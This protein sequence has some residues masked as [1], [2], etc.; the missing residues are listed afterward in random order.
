M[1][2]DTHCHLDASEFDADR[3]LVIQSAVLAGVRCIVIPAVEVANFE[4]VR[5][6]AHRLPHGAYALGIHP[7]FV[8]QAGEQDLDWLVQAL[9]RN[10]DDPKLVAVGEIGLD[11]FEPHLKDPPFLDKQIRIFKAQLSIAKM[12]QLPVILH[13]R[14]A[15]DLVLKYLRLAGLSG[16]IA[17]AFN[18]SFQQAQQFIDLGFALG[19][20][21]A[22]TFTRASQIRRLATE[23]PLENLVLET[24][25]PDIAPA[26]VQPD[27]IT[28]QRRNTPVHLLRIAQTIA[29]LRQCD[30]KTVI[31]TTTQTTHRVLPR[32]R[33]TD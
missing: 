17:H 16:G 18:G 25:S 10:R 30:I 19:M 13:V 33:S 31:D 24:D 14:R 21:G 32:L 27:C 7:L 5:Q 29:D 1:A 22:L 9:E 11:L 4:A 15:Q 12:F 28:A 20:G 6:L 26:W 23:I 8:P 2:I 3:E